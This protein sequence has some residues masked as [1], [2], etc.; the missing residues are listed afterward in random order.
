METETDTDGEN[1]MRSEDAVASQGIS[2][3][4]FNHQ[5]LEGKHGADSPSQHSGGTNSTDTLIP[6]IRL[7]TVRE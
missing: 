3:I 4:V 1:A 7:Q 6:D 2:R 5:E